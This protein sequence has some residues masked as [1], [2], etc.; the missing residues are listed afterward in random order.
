VTF[1]SRGLGPSAE[2]HING[3]TQ[4]IHPKLNGHDLGMRFAWPFRFD[5]GPHLLPSANQLE[6]SHVE[7][8]SYESKLGEVRIVPYL[9]L[10]I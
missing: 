3:M 10:E 8:Y 2:L 6:I 5:L 4:V 1:K 9:A 7:R